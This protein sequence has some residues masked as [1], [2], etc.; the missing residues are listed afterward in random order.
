LEN[1][2]VEAYHAAEASPLGLADLAAFAPERF[3]E[4]IFTLHPSVRLIRLLHPAASIW[5]AHQGEGEPQPPE[6]WAP[7]N[8]L[9]LRPDANVE[10]RVL[11]ELGFELALA[12]RAGQTLGEAATPFAG[13][14]EDVSAALIGLI[15]A[16]AIVAMNVIAGG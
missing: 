7:E 15:A 11:P 6:R 1:A 8:A 2:W 14:G 12:L 10:V 13:A 5:A 16:G 9:V 3:A 4:L